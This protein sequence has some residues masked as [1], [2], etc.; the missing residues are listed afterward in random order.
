[1]RR[2]TPALGLA[3]LGLGGC[4]TTLHM[5]RE[6]QVKALLGIPENVDTY[7]LIPIGYPA[8]GAG[9]LRRRPAAEVTFHDRWGSA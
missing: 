6:E 7:A 3:C 2:S 4:L 9:P 8:T 1:M 5:R